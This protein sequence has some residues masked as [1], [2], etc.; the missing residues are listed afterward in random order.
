LANAVLEYNMNNTDFDYQ[1][2]LAKLSAAIRGTSFL[3]CYWRTDKRRVKDPTGLNED[4]T[5]TYQEK[6]ITDFDDD[7]C[8]WVPNEFI[9]VD[10]KA[11]HISEA[12]DMFRREIINI[13]EFHRIY[14]NKPGF[15]D[16]ITSWPGGILLPVPS[17]SFQET[18]IPRTLKCCIITTAQ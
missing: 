16:T 15:Y 4:G 13:D 14:G 1:Y 6:E 11:K 3:M 10:E 8:E 5:I 17:S 2:F 7:Y 9:Y 18:L 12:T